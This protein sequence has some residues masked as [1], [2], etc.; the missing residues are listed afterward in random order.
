[1]DLGA[2]YGAIYRHASRLPGYSRYADYAEGAERAPDPLAYLAGREDSYLAIATVIGS[3]DPS[4]TRVLEV[5]SGLGYLTFAMR[6][7]GFEA[8]GVDLSA[9]AV[10]GATA[11]FGGFYECTTLGEWARRSTDR[12]D[13]V[14]MTELI[15][16]VPDPLSL[17]REAGSVLSTSGRLIVTTPNRD[18]Y[19]VEAT[20]RTEQP[21]VHLHWFSR[22]GLAQLGARAGFDC[23]Y[24]A[25]NDLADNVAMAEASMRPPLL[26]RRG[27]PWRP[28]LV[29]RIAR[30]L[31]RA[32]GAGPATPAAGEPIRDGSLF[33]VF[34][35]RAGA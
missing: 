24:L 10:E 35:P 34:T 29:R 13:V 32:V 8:I 26:D 3:L 30:R 15:E 4:R 18:A 6:K 19:P 20:W 5:G 17:L 23:T 11:R 21:P 7:R 33:A 1:M 28:S 25:I 31:A 9:S 2:L 12:F 27:E 16:H 14:V 22:A